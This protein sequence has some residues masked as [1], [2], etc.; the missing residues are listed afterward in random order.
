M[1][2]LDSEAAVAPGDGDR[3]LTRI[4]RDGCKSRSAQY[5]VWI[6]IRI[7]IPDVKKSFIVVVQIP[8]MQLLGLI[9]S[10]H[11]FQ[12]FESLLTRVQLDEISCTLC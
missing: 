10:Q 11:I 5:R 7:E 2:V 4:Q 3:M 12:T 6:Q 9:V 8:K 1:G